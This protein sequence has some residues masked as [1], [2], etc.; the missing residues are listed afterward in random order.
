MWSAVRIGVRHGDCQS[1]LAAEVSLLW[2]MTGIV[3]RCIN[4]RLID[5][6]HGH[7]LSKSAWPH[8]ERARAASRWTTT[9]PATTAMNGLNRDRIPCPSARRPDQNRHRLG[10]GWQGSTVRSILENPR[11]TGY[12]IFG[13]W[14]KS[15]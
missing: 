6:P 4:H 8:R 10:D 12:A 15:P 7:R 5:D 3:S 9:E 2:S 1:P 11:Y 14:T 13:R